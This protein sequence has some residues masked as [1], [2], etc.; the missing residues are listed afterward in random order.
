MNN[1]IVILKS[2]ILAIMGVGMSWFMIKYLPAPMAM[3]WL[4]SAMILDLITGLLK[5]WSKEICSTS[6]GFRKTIIKIGTYST[7]IVVVVILINMIGFMDV[8]NTYP[9]Q[10]LVNGLIG[11]MTFIELYS[12]CENISLAYPRSPL[13]Q[14]MIHPILKFL[15]GR[16]KNNPINKLNPENNS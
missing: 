8:N 14:Y 16:L 2:P 3:F 5:A 9:L 4:A 1:I 10:V 15:K 6:T 11:F 12:V 7:T 13:T